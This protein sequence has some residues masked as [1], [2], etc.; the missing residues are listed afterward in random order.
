MKKKNLLIPCV[1]PVESWKNKIKQSR[2]EWIKQECHL[3]TNHVYWHLINHHSWAQ[4]SVSG[5]GRGALLQQLTHRKFNQ[6]SLF[7]ILAGFGTRDG[8][9]TR[10]RYPKHWGHR[11]SPETELGRTHWGKKSKRKKKLNLGTILEHWQET[12]ESWHRQMERRTHTFHTCERTQ[13]HVK[14]M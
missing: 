1:K 7:N 3:Q 13:V 4:V 10:K 2:V 11:Q 14:K 8:S 12:E 5:N 9:Q 6:G